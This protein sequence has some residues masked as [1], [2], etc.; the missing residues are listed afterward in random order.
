MSTVLQIVLYE[1]VKGDVLA[2]LTGQE[3]IEETLHILKEKFRVLHMSE[4]VVILP[5]F[6]NLP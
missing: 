3:D 5:L 1:Q 4:S 2:F 6:A